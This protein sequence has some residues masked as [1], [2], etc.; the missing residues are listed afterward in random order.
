[1]WE[2]NEKTQ[3]YDS[4]VSFGGWRKPTYK[5]IKPETEEYG[6]ILKYLYYERVLIEE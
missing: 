6:V 4:F 1:M 3:N 2:T 5:Y